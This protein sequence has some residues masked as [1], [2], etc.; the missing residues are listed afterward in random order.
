MK[1]RLS[2]LKYEWVPVLLV[3]LT[4]ALVLGG[5]SNAQNVRAGTQ[6]EAAITVGVTPVTRKPIL[7]QLTLSS[8][9]VPFQEI[10][11]FAKESGYV[12]QIF[13]DYGTR[14]KKDQ[15]M[16]TLEIPELEIQLQQDAAA[17]QSATDQVSQRKNEISRIEAQ[18]KVVHLQAERMKGVVEKQPGLLAQQEIDDVVGKDLAAE[19][20]VEGGKSNLQT[21]ESQL[22][23]AKAKL[24]H[25]RVL[26]EYAQ[27]KAPFDGVVTERYAN[28][29]TLMQAGTSSST[30][31]LPLVKLS[32]D[33]LFRL[34]IPV[35]ESY[36][37]YI[38]IGDPV[39]VRV[40]A[41]DKVFPGKVKRFSTDVTA[42][43]RTMHTEVDVANPGRILIPGVYAEATL[44]LDRKNNALVVPLQAVNQNGQQATV[45]LVDDN[46][47]VEERKITLGLE[48]SSD[49]EVVS[50]LKD[51]DRVV[52]SDRSALKPGT[53]VKPQVV[54]LEQFQG[55]ND[56]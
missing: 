19:A 35:P 20:Q 4:M 14:V 23:G 1:F 33:D 30:Q 45:L 2:R 25:D 17:I 52:V 6:T 37:K 40:P 44:T 21:A 51:A 22:E 29:G 50:G 24:Q 8:E 49:A 11:V 18:H 28:L 36:V 38:R 46:N 42:E 53:V 34:V 3:V 55:G 41:L 7:R 39:Q 15:L 9:L 32:Q 12:R 26:F 54:A 47:K 10:D 56:Q 43:T 13:V 5:C 48:T 16:A 31:A 27:I